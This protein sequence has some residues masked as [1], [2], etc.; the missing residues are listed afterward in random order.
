M[1]N[2]TIKCNGETF[3]RSDYNGISILIRDADGYVNA[4]KLCNN[5]G[6]EFRQ[7]KRYD[8]WKEII[9]EF[10]GSGNSRHPYYELKNGYIGEL[11]GTYIHPDL[12]HFV[13]H[14]C[15]VK[16]AFKV[17]A[18]MNKL[19]ERQHAL[20]LEAEENYKQVMNEMQA[21]IDEQLKTIQEK[22]E[23]IEEQKGRIEEQQ[24]ELH[25]MSVQS[26]IN[27]RPLTFYLNEDDSIGLSADA[28]RHNKD[29][30]LKYILPA[31]MNIRMQL[32]RDFHIRNTSRITDDEY[33]DL[34]HYLDTLDYKEKI[35]GPDFI[36]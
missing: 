31:S 15:S 4:T 32:K 11:T 33:Y 8:E 13:A 9:E 1:E 27:S 6:K 18:I 7:Y 17:A 26:T 14:W 29:F 5:Y 28:K 35:E 16:Y 24:Q 20:Q 21:K 30:V 23:I 25:E 3:T 36:A 19:N 2:T 22:D 34:V 10:E 12:I